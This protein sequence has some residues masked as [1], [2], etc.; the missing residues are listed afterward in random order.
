MLVALAVGAQPGE[1]ILDL[2]AAPGG[3][4]ILLAECMANQGYLAAVE[5][6]RSRY[7]QLRRQL[8]LAGVRIARTFLSDGRRIGGKTP[9]RFD[10]V[11]LDAPCSG[12]ARF[13]AGDG[14]TWRYWSLQ[15]IRD[16]SRKQR[17]L[18]VSALRA[19]RPGGTLVY[20]TC[21][22]APE[23]NEAVL[24]FVLR[25]FGAS[26]QLLPM[27]LPISNVMPGLTRWRNRTFDP[28]LVHAARIL[29]TDLFDGFFLS[30]LTKTGPSGP[31]SLRKSGIR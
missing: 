7:Y 17:G 6:I 29:P 16:Q 28:S 1:Q 5:P 22:F 13:R 25:R 11:L 9:D 2:A 24:D 3:K 21:S 14:T 12:E 4:S 18:L 31:R 15:K 19:L 10:R 20:S 23:E 30:R 27:T 26:V 8:E